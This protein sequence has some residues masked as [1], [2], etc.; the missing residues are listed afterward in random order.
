MVNVRSQ[1]AMKN[2]AFVPLVC[3][4][5]LWPFFSHSFDFHVLG[6]T[7]EFCE[8]RKWKS[9][10]STFQYFNKLYFSNCRNPVFDSFLQW[11]FTLTVCWFWRKR[12]DVFGNFN[13]H[14][15]T[16]VEWSISLQWTKNG[17]NGRLHITKFDWWLRGISLWSWFWCCC[18]K[19]N[20]FFVNHYI[21]SNMLYL[22]GALK[23]SP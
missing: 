12:H 3:K 18:N 1:T 22:T 15:A 11:N 13:C 23:Q 9:L 20:N 5:L 14:Q 4:S 21:N 6:Y 2:C 16:Y 10:F 19:V 8:I 17:Q 7:G